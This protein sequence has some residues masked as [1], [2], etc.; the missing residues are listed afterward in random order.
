MKGKIYQPAWVA[1]EVG[2]SIVQLPGEG[3]DLTASLGGSRGRDQHCLLPGKGKDL[4]VHSAGEAPE[5][6]ITIIQ[7]PGELV[8]MPDCL[9]GLR[10]RVVQLSR[11]G[12]NLRVLASLGCSSHIDHHSSALKIRKRSISQTCTAN[13]G[14]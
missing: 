8:D 1:P 7:L 3:E 9:G 13:E 5:M 14:R 4:P 11:E 10:G 12:K 6:G 2:I